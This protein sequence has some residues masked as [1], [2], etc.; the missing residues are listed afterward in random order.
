MKGIVAEVGG[1]GS[2]IDV[3]FGAQFLADLCDK[4]GIAVLEEVLRKYSTDP[5]FSWSKEQYAIKGVK[6]PEDTPHYKQ[7]KEDFERLKNCK[8]E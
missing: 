5:R 8:P 3:A 4:R 2:E 6:Y 7:I 1:G